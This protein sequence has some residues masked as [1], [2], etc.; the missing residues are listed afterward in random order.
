MIYTHVMGKGAHG[1]RSSLDREG[2]LSGSQ[3]AR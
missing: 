2:A 3:A 1:V